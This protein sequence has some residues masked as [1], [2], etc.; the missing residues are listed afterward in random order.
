MDRIEINVGQAQKQIDAALTDT[1]KA[2]VR[3]KRARKMQLYCIIFGIAV[4]L[5][6][7][8]ALVLFFIVR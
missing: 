8:L 4:L 5:I 6:V 7:I 2:V 1:K 3:K